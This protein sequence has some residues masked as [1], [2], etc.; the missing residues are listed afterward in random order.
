METMLVDSRGL[1]KRIV[2]I[3]KQSKSIKE[4]EKPITGLY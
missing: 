3:R 1:D 2:E 4:N